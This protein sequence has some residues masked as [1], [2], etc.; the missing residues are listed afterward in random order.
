[1]PAVDAT[2]HAD[3]EIIIKAFEKGAAFSHD[4]K[5]VYAMN[6]AILSKRI[7][8]ANSIDK[9][10]GIQFENIDRQKRNIGTNE[11]G[12]TEELISNHP[13]SETIT[14]QAEKNSQASHREDPSSFVNSGAEV[15]QSD[16]PWTDKEF[17]NIEQ[18]G[19]EKCIPCKDRFAGAEMA[20]KNFGKGWEDYGKLWESN[21]ENFIKQLEQ[22]VE[23]LKDRGRSNLL[24]LCEFIGAFDLLQCPSDLM[25]IIAALSAAL[26]KISIDIFGDLGMFLNLAKGILTPLLSAAVQ[27]MQNFIQRILDPIHCIIA[28][29]YTHLTLPTKA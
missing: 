4:P 10:I 3:C 28:V 11:P 26:T 7:A 5:S 15:S 27:L 25:R 14:S 20:I 2:F 12:I 17:K 16:T 22:I 29:S 9:Q 23:M 8:N 18:L 6:T 24:A 19:M 1:M 13:K 21:L